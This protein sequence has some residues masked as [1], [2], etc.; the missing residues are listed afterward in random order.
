MRWGN[1]GIGKIRRTKSRIGSLI[2]RT[3]IMGVRMME[4]IKA[5]IGSW[6]EMWRNTKLERW[7]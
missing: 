3:P 1:E 4:D 6:Q 2:V 5:A 7:E